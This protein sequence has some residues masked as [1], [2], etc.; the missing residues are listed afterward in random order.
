MLYLPGN[1]YLKMRDSYYNLSEG[2]MS[3]TG[4][5]LVSFSLFM[6]V[7]QLHRINHSAS[8]GDQVAVIL[9]SI[10]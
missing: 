9:V 10:A 8:A 3:L 2:E 4:D 1:G 7:D 5:K 6:N